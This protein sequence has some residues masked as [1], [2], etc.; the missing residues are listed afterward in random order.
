MKLIRFLRTDCLLPESLTPLSRL[1]VSGRT[2][3]YPPV[4]RP[5]FALLRTERCTIRFSA[6]YHV[7]SW[8]TQ[9]PS[10]STFVM[11]DDISN[12]QRKRA[13]EIEACATCAASVQWGRRNSSLTTTTYFIAVSAVVHWGTINRKRIMS[14]SN[15]VGAFDLEDVRRPIAKKRQAVSPEIEITELIDAVALLGPNE[16]ECRGWP[17]FPS[18]ERCIE[19]LEILQQVSIIRGAYA[20]R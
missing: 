5:L 9:R 2:K 7:S 11:C 3:S 16:V 18:Q 10:S 1:V 14:S 20:D 12:S 8:V 13:A 17:I 15:P 6:S 4:V 19:G